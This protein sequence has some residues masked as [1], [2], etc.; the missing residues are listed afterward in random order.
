[1]ELQKRI[2]EVNYAKYRI[3]EAYYRFAPKNIETVMNKTSI[4]DVKNGDVAN[5]SGTLMLVTTDR[6]GYSNNR[7]TTLNNTVSYMEQHTDERP[8]IL[9]GNDCSLSLVEFLSLDSEKNVTNQ[10]MQFL[11]QLDSIPGHGF[12]SVFLYYADFQ[13]GVV[14]IS[15]Q[16]LTFLNYEYGKEYEDYARFFREMHVR[17][18]VTEKVK[19]RENVGES[20]YIGYIRLGKEKKQ[21]KLYE[22]LDACPMRERQAK[23]INKE[24]FEATIKL[25]YKK[26]FYEARNRFSEILKECPEDDV[27]RWYLFES[28]KYLNEEQPGEN[29]GAF[30]RESVRE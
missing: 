25:F 17:L 22:I 23:M 10:S 6:Y 1:M 5:V 19:K 3:F 16:S 21:V 28:E 24:K 30:R 7:A 15:A 8:V 9:V 29:F 13:Y 18:I 11:Q 20:R 4:F 26:A 14:G 2:A 12:V 27:A